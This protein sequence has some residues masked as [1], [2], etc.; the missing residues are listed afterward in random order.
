MER[1]I[2]IDKLILIIINANKYKFKSG[3]LFNIKN[4]KNIKNHKCAIK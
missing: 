4:Y 3:F 2:R 1:G